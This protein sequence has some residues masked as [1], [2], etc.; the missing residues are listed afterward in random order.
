MTH[1]HTIILLYLN[2]PSALILVF[3]L[4]LWRLNGDDF[5]H[6][7]IGWIAAFLSLYSCNEPIYVSHIRNNC[8]DIQL[9]FWWVLSF[10]CCCG[11]SIVYRVCF[12]NKIAYLFL[13][14]KF[15]FINH[16][17]QLL[18]LFDHSN[19]VI[20]KMPDDPHWKCQQVSILYY[21]RNIVC[22]YFWS[23][24]N[25]AE[26]YVKVYGNV[27]HSCFPLLLSVYV[28]CNVKLIDDQCHCLW[29]HIFILETGFRF[30]RP[31]HQNETERKTISSMPW[32]EQHNSTILNKIPAAICLFIVLLYMCYCGCFFR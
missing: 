20:S 4:L 12:K 2:F 18:F 21:T 15:F 24:K 10:S 28:M 17:F 8:S 14:D 1:T 32:H 27:A 16:S 29:F 22:N 3:V 31:K 30:H 7:H 23:Y 13:A 25:A 11:F 9:V 26:D 6:D 5:F 19:F